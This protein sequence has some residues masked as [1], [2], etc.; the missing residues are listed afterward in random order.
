[1]LCVYMCLCVSLVMTGI[2][3]SLSLLF[4]HSAGNH[5]SVNMNQMYG[6]EGEVKQKY[7]LY[8]QQTSILFQSFLPPPSS[9]LTSH[10]PP[11]FPTPSPFSSLP[12][13]PQLFPFS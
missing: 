12:Y 5:E 11:S 10:L 1:M 8:L 3:L 4:T 2:S 9:P 6:F 7:P 13:S